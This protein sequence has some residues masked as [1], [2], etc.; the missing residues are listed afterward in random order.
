MS[1]KVGETIK[2]VGEVREN[3][4]LQ[5]L[6]TWTITAQ[7]KKDSEDGP[8]LGNFTLS[9]PGLGLFQLTLATAGFVPCQ[10]FFDVRIVRPDGTI[11]YTDTDKFPLL[12]AV[13]VP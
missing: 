5:N 9:L 13:T 10:V 11:C 4:V 6:S 2:Y 3:G 7:A 12:K 8:L 1:Y